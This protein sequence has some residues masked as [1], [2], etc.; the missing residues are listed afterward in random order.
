MIKNLE[1]WCFEMNGTPFTL[2]SKGLCEHI[3]PL[4][5]VKKQ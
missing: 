3:E 1:K 4:I 5:A 2:N